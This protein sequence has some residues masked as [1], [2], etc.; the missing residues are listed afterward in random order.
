MPARKGMRVC[1]V[2]GCPEL[3]RG[4]RCPAHEGAADLARGNA[5]ERGYDARHRAFRAKVLRRDPVCVLCEVRASTD[6]DHYPLDRR[7]LVLRG[8]DPNDPKHGRG[9]CGHCHKQETAINQPGGFN[10]P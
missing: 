3:T 7:T 1:T 2:A 6:A 10:A 4:G 9:L 8:E 5:T